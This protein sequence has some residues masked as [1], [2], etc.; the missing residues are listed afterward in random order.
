MADTNDRIRRRPV[1]ALFGD[2]D[3]AT[4][5]YI[6]EPPQPAS[7]VTPPPIAQAPLDAPP[8]ALPES[9]APVA[10]PPVVKVSAPIAPSAPTTPPSAEPALPS[11]AIDTPPAFVERPLS[12]V[13]EARFS[14]LAER[15]TRLYGDV[16]LDLRD[17]PKSAEF[18]MGL[19]LQ[20]RQAIETRNFPVAENCI[21]RVDIKLKLSAKSMQA[22]RGLGMIGLWLWQLAML[23]LGAGLVLL[24][25]V[26]NLTLFGLP[27]APQANILVRALGWG[28]IGGV[29][30]ALYNITWFIQFREYDPAY[31]MDYFA[32]PFKG[33]I[34]GGV[35]FVIS[36]AGIIA[37]NVTLPNNIQLGPIFLYAIAAL[38]GF[39]QEYV[40]EFFD[41]L[42]KS[43][44]RAPHL[45]KEL[46]Q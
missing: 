7:T 42:L 28:I 22:A 44:F 29:L 16:K 30:G 18:C 3:D 6:V 1:D 11:R 13:E 12:F 45:P 10:P 34:V 21:E 24:T 15:V 46:K 25:Y 5:N 23:A 37:G 17:S 40:T 4:P 35:L 27:V 38:A 39:K 32:R 41:S 20:A 33:M 43:V 9:V 19:L 14:A 31:T 26:I 8:T 36:E 2:S